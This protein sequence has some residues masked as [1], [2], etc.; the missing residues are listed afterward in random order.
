M[1]NNERDFIMSFQ[2]GF[3]SLLRYNVKKGGICLKTVYKNILV[4]VDGSRQAKQAFKE[5]LEVTKRNQGNLTILAVVDYKYAFGDPAF[6]NDAI[7]IH[8]NNAELEVDALL[9][10]FD[11]AE[12]DF[13]KEILSGSP[14]RQIVDYAKENQI[15]LIMIGATGTGAFE[16][17]VLG[18][19]T[20]Y[21]VN[22]AP[23]NVM[24]VKEA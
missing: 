23:C 21:V 12:I 19:T 3:F 15:D 16:Q 13:K 14:K 2:K 17:M 11:L 7:S 4:A 18:S 20:A 9:S 8:M 6:I 10:E 5:A 24:V 22:H 1:L